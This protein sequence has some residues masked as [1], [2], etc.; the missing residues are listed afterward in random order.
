MPRNSSLKSCKQLILQPLDE[1]KNNLTMAQ[2][3]QS[4]PA[5]V[6]ATWQTSHV[7]VL[8]AASLLAGLVAGYPAHW[9]VARPVQRS[10]LLL[11]PRLK[12][13]AYIHR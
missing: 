9:E 3:R 2:E 6:I 13:R 1:W 8:V 4:Q 5:S 12:R 10:R 7:W 11:P